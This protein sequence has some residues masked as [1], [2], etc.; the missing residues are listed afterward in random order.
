MPETI[1][2]EV[3]GGSQPN[4]PS[5]GSGSLLM[6]VPGLAF[7]ALGI[8]VIYKPQVL[9]AMVAGVFFLIGLGL[10]LGAMAFRRAKK[11]FSSFAQFSSFGQQR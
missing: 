8:L 10:L 2:V 7:I 3:Q 5:S 11:R 4:P 6:M 1:H 9:I